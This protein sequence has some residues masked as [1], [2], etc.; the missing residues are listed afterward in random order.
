MQ[1]HKKI[2][3]I[4]PTRLN[5]AHPALG[6]LK[7]FWSSPDKKSEKFDTCHKS[8]NGR[9]SKRIIYYTADAESQFSP[10]NDNIAR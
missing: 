4:V 2:V 10:R 6:L 3:Y 5:V 9:Q 8:N 7:F 1:I